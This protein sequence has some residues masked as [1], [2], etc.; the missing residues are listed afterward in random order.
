MVE[1]LLHSLVAAMI[2]VL[3]VGVFAGCTT[4][5]PDMSTN[6]AIGIV[7]MVKSVEKH[8]ERKVH[9]R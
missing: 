7:N 3:I 4:Q 2:A 6:E 9:K 5:A 1:Q 8:H